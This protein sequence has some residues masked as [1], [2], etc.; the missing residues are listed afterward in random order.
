MAMG[1]LEYFEL[2]C[3][4]GNVFEDVLTS[5]PFWVIWTSPLKPLLFTINAMFLKI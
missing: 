2:F 5:C 3:V 1:E 4:V